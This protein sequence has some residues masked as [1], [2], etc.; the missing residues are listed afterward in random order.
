[1]LTYSKGNWKRYE[2]VGFI[3]WTYKDAPFLTIYKDKYL[4]TCLKEI[5]YDQS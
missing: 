5:E 3:L 4:N 1:M 2:F